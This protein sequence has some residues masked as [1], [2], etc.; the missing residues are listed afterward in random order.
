MSFTNSFAVRILG[1][2]ALIGLVIW[3]ASAANLGTPHGLDTALS[4]VQKVVGGGGSASDATASDATATATATP[5]PSASASTSTTSPST[6][7]SPQTT[8]AAA[9][10]AGTAATT[11][12]MA[13]ITNTC[14]PDPSL[15]KTYYAGTNC[16]DPALRYT[17]YLV[18]L[19]SEVYK[20]IG[21][22]PKMVQLG[23]ETCTELATYD[24][25]R[26]QMDITQWLVA[27]Q[28]PTNPR[29]AALSVLNAATKNLCP[30]LRTKVS[31]P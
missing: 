28:N 23:Q 2:V 19:S 3:G 15:P 7:A 17:H 9:G 5:A 1:V 20:V 13:T 6:A 8:A 16:A 10:T 31:I 12:F 26:V 24:S 25:T 30:A 18:T 29:S 4:G 11:P 21:Y 14:I 27:E 22:Q